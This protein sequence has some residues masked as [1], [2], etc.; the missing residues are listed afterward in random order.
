MKQRQNF[1]SLQWTNKK[2]QRE[3]SSSV[4]QQKKNHR[5]KKTRGKNDEEILSYPSSDRNGLKLNFMSP[6]S[7]LLL[8]HCPRR[9][10]IKSRLK[11]CH[12]LSRINSFFYHFQWTEKRKKKVLKTFSFPFSLLFLPADDD[13]G[14]SLEKPKP[15]VP[16]KIVN[17]SK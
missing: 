4:R 6:S 9:R 2:R 14:R 16:M 8:L 12:R 11:R 1:T 10:G 15:L 13:T 5:E 7:P 3:K 17:V